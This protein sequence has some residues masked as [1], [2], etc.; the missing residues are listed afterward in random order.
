MTIVTLIAMVAF[1]VCVLNFVCWKILEPARSTFELRRTPINEPL[2][3]SLGKQLAEP[4]KTLFKGLAFNGFA[5]HGSPFN[6]EFPSEQELNADLQHLKSYST[7]LRTYSTSELPSLPRLAEP[8][9]IL[10]SLG[11]W[12]SDDEA[13]NS[14]EI[15][16]AVAA[17]REHKNIER[18]IVGNETLLRLQFSPKALIKHLDQFKATLKANSLSIPVSTAEPWHIWL[19]YPELAEHVDFITV[20]L[21]PYW[22]GIQREDAMN[23]VLNRYRDLQKRFPGKKIV[24]GE[25]GWPSAGGTIKFATPSAFNQAQ[26]LNEL[27]Q[28]K[29]PLDYFV[30]EAIDQV[31][32]R[33]SEGEVGAFWGI[34]NANR[35]SKFSDIERQRFTSFGLASSALGFALCLVILFKLRHLRLPAAIVLALVTQALVSTIAALVYQAGLTYLS[36]WETAALVFVIPGLMLLLVTF[37]T[38]TFEFCETFWHGSLNRLLSQSSQ[39]SVT[40]TAEALPFVSIH[41]AC[42][43]EPTE[44]VIASVQSAMALQYPHF[45][46]IIVDNNTTDPSLTLALDLQVR[47]LCERNTSNPNCSVK[48]FQLGR[49]PGFKAGALNYALEQTDPRAKIVAIFDA[50]YQVSPTWLADLAPHFASE[51]VTV[52]QSPQAHRGWSKTSVQRFMNW[53]YD[54]F[55]RIGMHHRN[56][57]NAIIQHGTMC[58]VRKA[59]L[60]QVGGWA[61][62]G[63]CEDTELGLR[64]LAQGGR[65]LY[66]D[67][68]YGAGL[69]P[70]TFNAYRKQRQRWAAGGMQIMRKHA[71]ILLGRPFSQTPTRQARLTVAQ[72]YHFVAGWL[73]WL[74]DALHLLFSIALII[75]TLGMVF[76]P[77]WLRPAG[78]IF[79]IPLV[80][81][82]MLRALY[83]VL[84]YRSKVSCS[85]R[86]LFGAMLFGMGLSHSIAKGVVNGLLGKNL[87]FIVTRKAHNQVNETH[88]PLRSPSIPSGHG[89]RE[90][91]FL[92]LALTAVAALFALTPSFQKGIG[93][94]TPAL[95]LILIGLQALPYISA[96]AAQSICE[97]NRRPPVGFS[98]QA[99]T[100]P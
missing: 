93:F 46:I 71:R 44:M 10:L 37:W 88:D 34:L 86:D 2:S 53:E 87:R 57:R 1:G 42:C 74:G 65:C 84:L 28:L 99:Q 39:R 12:I 76:A 72:S 97:R 4:N 45:E 23:Y 3:D 29:Q 69:T 15:A 27:S 75:W 96:L 82:V 100:D 7:R 91:Q 25:I 35:E 73:P 66:I 26:F 62:D 90:E 95:W 61:L 83:T 13:Q 16:A 6:R 52:V 79:L 17:A 80:S 59:S 54:G 94:G 64:L 20:H 30:M 22:E 98:S 8:L 9:G 47:H 5:R 85:W 24:I 50:D 49:W 31:W 19:Q 81:T 18:F 55:F 51:N 63:L 32:K 78:A 38:Q 68:E 21:L 92:L 60:L 70:E 67:K 41:L 11:L 33:Q 48:L 56:V 40:T 14:R 77:Q 36:P 58:L 89:L 43:N